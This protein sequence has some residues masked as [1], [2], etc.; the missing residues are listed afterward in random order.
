VAVVTIDY[1]LCEASGVCADVCPDDVFEHKEG[2]TEVIDSQACSL[3]WKCVESCT[4][5]AIELD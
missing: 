5:G 3:C 1:E 4:S 2:R